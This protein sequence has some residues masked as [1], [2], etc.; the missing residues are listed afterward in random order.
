MQDLKRPPQVL[1]GCLI[2]PLSNTFA[3]S[4]CAHDRTWHFVEDLRVFKA[5]L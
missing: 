4:S 5:I 3:L 2:P 1:T